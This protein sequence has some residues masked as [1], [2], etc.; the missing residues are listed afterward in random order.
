[1]RIIAVWR[2]FIP[3]KDGEVINMEETMKLGGNIELSGFSGLDKASVVVLK[4]IVG[5]YAKRMSD[6][7][8][9]FETLSLVMKKIHETEAS[10]KFEIHAKMLDNGKPHVSEVVDRNLFVAIDNS[11]KK[12]VN[13]LEK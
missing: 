1:M 10:K 5:N 9:N 3:K 12:I 11:L 8:M 4:K 6:I 13:S 2:S 7:S